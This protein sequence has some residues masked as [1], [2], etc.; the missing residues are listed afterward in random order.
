MSRNEECPM[1]IEVLPLSAAAARL[2]RLR[3]S[4]TSRTVLLKPGPRNTARGARAR[5]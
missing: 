5:P 3:S 1:S 2:L 4:A